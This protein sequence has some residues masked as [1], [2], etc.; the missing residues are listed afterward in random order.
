MTK[1]GMTWAAVVLGVLT[2]LSMIVS[3]SPPPATEGGDPLA[4]RAPVDVRTE[5]IQAAPVGRIEV[6]GTVEAATVADLASRVAAVIEKLDVEEGDTVRRGQILVR[7]DG[8]DLRAQVEA[9]EA[10]LR[11]ATAHDARIRSLFEKEAATRQE[12]E[13]AEEG[14]SAAEA[15]VETAKAQLDYVVIR[16]PFDGRVAVKSASAG[17]LAS[18][19]R[20]LLTLQASGLMRVSATVSPD[21]VSGLAIGSPVEVALGGGRT[22]RATISVMSPSS[23]P[24]SRRLMVKADLPS[25]A[26]IRAGSF[27]RLLLPAATAPEPQPV[28]P[29]SA[30]V[31][32]GALTGLYVVEE[33]RARLRWISVGGTVGDGVIVRA[34]LSPGDEVILD[35]AGLVDGAPV[36]VASAG[37]AP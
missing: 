34:G 9:A 13:S 35:P 29:G 2:P 18:P 12:L 7:L 37:A 19:G 26:T 28:A 33:G 22:A 21:Q 8:R 4:S 31:R 3:C 30:L 27:V 1:R 14:R 15:A 24:V 23:D 20:S 32:H 36:R 17:D 10:A 25:D 16:A 6:P 11:A 5:R